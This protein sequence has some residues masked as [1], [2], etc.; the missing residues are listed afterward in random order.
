MGRD[1]PVLENS[2]IEV[3]PA[4]IEAGQAVFA[5]VWLEFISDRGE[6]LWP[7]LLTA[8]YLVM[9]ATWRESIHE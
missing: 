9:K 6:E 8:A 7:E 4:M 3:T 2:A 5:S 1:R